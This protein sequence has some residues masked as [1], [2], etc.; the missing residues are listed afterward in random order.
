MMI[1]AAGPPFFHSLS[2]LCCSAAGASVWRQPRTRS[3]GPC[4]L[5]GEREEA[6]RQPESAR[7]GRQTDKTGEG[8]GEVYEKEG[9][10]RKRP[11]VSL[12]DFI[13]ESVARGL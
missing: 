3:A 1:P 4:S 10:K 5:P 8:G 11:N 7:G 6:E 13:S 2:C 9:T 12:M